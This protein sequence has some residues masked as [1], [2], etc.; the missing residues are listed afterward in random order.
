MHLS[1][2]ALVKSR[3]VL[4][5]QTPQIVIYLSYR[6]LVAWVCLCRAYL[7]SLRSGTGR[8]RKGFW[9]PQLA[10]EGPCNRKKD[11]VTENSGILT[12][13][14]VSDVRFGL[15]GLVFFSL[16]LAVLPGQSRSG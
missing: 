4:A 12:R 2:K 1:V 15:E 3:N 5:L 14:M 11:H 6:Q 10:K 13:Y 8:R 7:L 16:A 9:W